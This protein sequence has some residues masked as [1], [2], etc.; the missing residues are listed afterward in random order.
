MVQHHCRRASNARASSTCARWRD[1]DVGGR[2]YSHGQK[3]I[4]IRCLYVPWIARCGLWCVRRRLHLASCSYCCWYLVGFQHSDQRFG[5]RHFQRHARSSGESGDSKLPLQHTHHQWL[6]PS[7]T[8]R[9]RLLPYS[10][11]VKWFEYCPFPVR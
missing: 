1:R 11:L 9:Q 7:A 5:H 3:G 2:I 4:P 6:Q 10:N 8:L